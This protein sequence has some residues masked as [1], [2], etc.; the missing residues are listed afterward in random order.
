[1]QLVFLDGWLA[2]A[3]VRLELS[4]RSVGVEPPQSGVRKRDK[5]STAQLF[6]IFFSLGFYTA[7][8]GSV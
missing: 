8:V 6:L 2:L 3:E 5:G 1:M 4:G 7:Q